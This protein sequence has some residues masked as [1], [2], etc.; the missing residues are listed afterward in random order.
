M[1]RGL[2]GPVRLAQVDR[3][4]GRLGLPGRSEPDG[5]ITAVN[6]P[7][8]K[9]TLTPASACTV[10]CPVP[11]VLRRSTECA[12]GSVFVPLVSSS[13]LSVMFFLAML[14]GIR[15]EQRR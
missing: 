2:P 15:S 8:S 13:D 4:R 9:V 11:Y 12:A 7:R 10:A 3:M 6:R 5:P 1:H 14:A